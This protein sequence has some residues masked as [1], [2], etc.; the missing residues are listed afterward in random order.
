MNSALLFK[1]IE[2]I[3]MYLRNNISAFKCLKMN[4]KCLRLGSIYTKISCWIFDAR[5][6]KSELT[7]Y[8]ESFLK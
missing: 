7:I 4:L 5:T 2:I 8:K 6:R 3:D 1:Q